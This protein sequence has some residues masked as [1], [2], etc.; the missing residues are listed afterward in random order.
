MGNMHSCPQKA[1]SL[2]KEPDKQTQPRDVGTGQ[3]SLDFGGGLDTYYDLGQVTLPIL[4]LS[5]L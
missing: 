2:V 4:N 3:S 5:V 1:E